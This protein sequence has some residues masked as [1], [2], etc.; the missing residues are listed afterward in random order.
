M[1]SNLSGGLHARQKQHRRQNSTPTA[2]EGAK[3][4]NLPTAQRQTAHR[5][6]LSLDIRRQH[7]AASP[8][9]TT[10]PT[11][12]NQMV[13]TN[14]NNT[15][16]SHYPQHNVLREAQ[17]QRIQARPGTQ[18]P[19]ANLASSAS[20][21]Y[22][23]SPHGTPQ[24]QRFDPSCFDPNSIPF[25]TYNTDF[26]V[27]MSKGQQAY[28]DNLSGGK[29]FDLFNNDSALSTPSFMTF[30]SEGSS[31]QGWASEGDT[32]ST[33]RTSRRI[34]GGI[35]DRVNKFENLDSARPATP[36]SQNQNQGHST[37]S[38]SFNWTMPLAATT[39]LEKGY[40][41]PTPTETSQDRLVKD[42]PV[43]SRF[44]DDYDESMEE[45]I[46]PVRNRGG[47]RRVQTIFQ[48]I[49][50]HSEQD[51]SSQGQTDSASESSFHALPMSTP[52]YMNMNNFN[53]EFMK[54]ENGF[55]RQ[56]IHGLDITPSTP[57]MSHFIDLRPYPMN[58]QSISGTPSQTPSR[59]H[60]PHR[61]TESV[62]SIA[63]AASIASI[64]IEETKTETGVTQDEIAQFISGPDA[65]DGKWTCTYEDC[66]KK[67]GRKENIKSHVQT[68]LNDRQYQCPTCKKCF[69]RQHDLKRHA[70]IHTGIKPYPCECG[71]S[72]ARHDALTR[73]R[74]R[75]MCI[76][77]FD[78]VVRK[79]VKRGRPPKKS[80]PDIETRM[81]KSARTR[82]KNMSIS[83]MSSFSACSDSSAVTSPDQ[84][85]LDDMMDMGMPSQS[86]NLAAVSSAPMTGLTAAALQEYASSPSAVSAHSY[87]SPEAIMDGTPM[88]VASPAKSAA[89]QYNT[90]PELSQSSSPPGT[91]YFEVEQNNSMNTDDL[92]AIPGTS[93]YVTSATM[94]ATLPL[95]M[96]S[97]DDLLLQFG[98]D[99]GL[100]Q[101]DRDS[102]MLSMGK[103]ED[104]EF[105]SSMF[106][107][108]DNDVFFGSN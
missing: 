103:F 89:S 35:L 95:G 29:E 55:G 59:R 12:Q 97:A 42:E 87:V 30:P 98:G 100:I 79:V 36:P 82:K 4:P 37:Q 34:S 26:N 52:D 91:H 7:I 107:N 66:G 88:H 53:N 1:Q 47:N 44:S 8:A 85:M 69:V 16:L 23:M 43:P 90:P 28:G 105:E 93:T 18:N 64:N 67:F 68:H 13:G 78:N 106:A 94:A 58:A 48:D 31:A 62:A 70:K 41:P 50:Q 20:D 49:R 39:N 86:Q 74:Q 32:S 60:S 73:H 54:I 15:G 71:N 14:T 11:R 5:R 96:S 92:T 61:R 27:M 19:Y 22:L 38:Q 75:G 56:E 24:T 21:N 33:R 46:K 76:G 83:S 72:F 63:S 3:I 65:G 80:R 6:G 9:T 84:F 104:D 108:N 40:F 101:L 10:T 57:H 77:A 51:M 2:F 102:H 17:Q 25:D 99:N 45:T 81:D